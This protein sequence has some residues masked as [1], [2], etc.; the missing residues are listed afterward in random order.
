MPEFDTTR[1]A[2]DGGQARRHPHSFCDTSGCYARMGFTAED[3]QVFRRGAR[4]RVVVV[5][6]LAPD[7]PA[8]L[9]MSLTGFTAGLAAV[10]VSDD[11]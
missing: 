8:E 6:A 10:E 1:F 7:Q 4:A 3:V 2:V 11:G 5:P 9:I